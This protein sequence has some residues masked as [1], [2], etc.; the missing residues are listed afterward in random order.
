MCYDVMKEKKYLDYQ[1]IKQKDFLTRIKKP[2]G[3]IFINELA[4]HIIN[5]NYSRCQTMTFFN[6]KLGQ[7]GIFGHR[8]RA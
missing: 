2:L 3:F 8:Q 6:L 5:P 7:G 1:G 4:T